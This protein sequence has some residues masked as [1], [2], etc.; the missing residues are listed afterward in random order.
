[1]NLSDALGSKPGQT[2]GPG[3]RRE[4]RT[5]VLTS[6]MLKC[7]VYYLDSF[8][9]VIAAL[10]MDP[11]GTNG[12]ANFPVALAAEFNDDPPDTI[13]TAVEARMIA[14]L[15]VSCLVFQRLQSD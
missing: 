13:G 2:V 6:A 3:F 15:A 10:R 12:A 1:M 7:P 8:A 11:P 9:L 4:T 14:F 5:I